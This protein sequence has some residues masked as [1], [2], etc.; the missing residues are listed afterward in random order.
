MLGTSGLGR[1]NTLLLAYGIALL[2]IVSCQLVAGV[3][4]RHL[5]PLGVGC[6]LPGGSGPQVRV[7][8][9]VPTSDV[10]DICIRPAGTTTWGRPVLIN[11]GVDGPSDAGEPSCTT[12]LGA[13]GFK[14]G[15]VSIPF[16]APASSI[17]VKFIPG[18]NTCEAGAL[19]EGD[20]LALA[21]N[22]T[23]TL[24][25]IGGNGVSTQIVALPEADTPTTSGQ[26]FRFVHAAPGTGPMDFGVTKDRQPPT[27]L[28][29]HL[30]S[31]PVPFGS[32]EPS[33]ATS[34]LPSAT[35]VDNG[36]LNFLNG[37]FLLG[38]AKD[39]DSSNNA[40]FAFDENTIPNHG[41]QAAY[42]VYAVGV[43]GDNKHPLQ[44]YICEE[45]SYV[46][47]TINPLLIPCTTSPLP[48]ISVDVFNPALYG[49]NSPYFVNRDG[50]VPAAI[51]ARNSDV[52]CLLEVDQKSDRDNIIK[53]ATQ[54]G[55]NYTITTTLDTQPTNPANQG[56]QVPPPPSNP[57]C[58]GVPSNLVDNA[59]TCLEQYCST[60]NPGD[61]TGQLKGSTDCILANCASDFIQIQGSTS[62]DGVACY[63]CMVVYVASETTFEATQNSCT[64][65]TRPPLGF[66]GEQNSMI[67][68]R[69]PLQN[70]DALVLPSTYYRRMVLY[71]Q[72]QLENQSFD[73]YC[74]FLMTTLNDKALP[75]DGNY[76]VG[77]LG[78]G[79][80]QNSTVGWA[81]EQLFEAQQLI[82]WVGQ[83]SGGADGGPGNPAIVVG[84]WRSSK[85]Y[86][87]DAGNVPPT[88]TFLPVGLAEDTMNLFAKTSWTFVFDTTQG[89]SWGHQCNYC[90]TA[91]NPLNTN[92]SFFVEQPFLVNWPVGSSGTAADAV[93]S[94][95]LIFTQNAFPVGDGGQQGPVSPY[96]GL[97]F[98]V[99]RPPH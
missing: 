38:A 19:S 37:G 68:S 67:L 26:S 11:G 58:Q 95:Q 93:K 22:A 15:Q 52:M 7:A 41:G 8:N 57:P 86:P 92:E 54:Y 77:P 49:A 80:P 39:G 18:G 40:L 21:S 62:G 53:A 63:N 27:T 87:A 48:L 2:A 66:S 97:N 25:S 59:F 72:V 51:A 84:D 28:L 64:T 10:V 74:G 73:F 12:Q 3:D 16:H 90:P 61:P 78:N 46:A 83:K 35:L 75:Y 14:Y 5:D 23:T 55:Y 65:D 81:N 33:D 94:E 6:T 43:A 9:F 79:G 60:Q 91:E 42:S 50:L 76:G 36:Y 24:V 99:I 44:A 30:L 29:S 98:T 20:G 85:G 47:G 82:N 96:Y 71:S 89:T 31:L 1:R 56:G 4:T 70:T 34:L 17:D 32:T 69:Y 13:M 88:G 45:D